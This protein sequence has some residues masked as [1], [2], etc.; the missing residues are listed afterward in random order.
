MDADTKQ[1][2]IKIGSKIKEI[3]VLNKTVEVLNE[4][5]SK[6]SKEIENLDAKS[7][8]GEISVVNGEISK[9]KK[10]QKDLILKSSANDK[11]KDQLFNSMKSMFT[12]AYNNVVSDF[13]DLG[14]VERRT[15]TRSDLEKKGQ[16]ALNFL[17]NW[18]EKGGFE[19]D[20]II[21]A[22]EHFISKFDSKEEL[23]VFKI[24]FESILNELK[25]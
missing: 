3:S 12:D 17:E 13:F 8:D 16:E 2:A 19:L 20:V 6:I 11:T 4:S 10:T 24:F 14:T 25:K 7:K 18:S 22:I 23:K 9:L 1:Q 5:I 15:I 21:K